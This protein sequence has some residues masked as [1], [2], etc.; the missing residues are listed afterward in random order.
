[1]RFQPLIGEAG[2]PDALNLLKDLAFRMETYRNL[3]SDAF[4]I[5]QD[6]EVRH[7]L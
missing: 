6:L 1:M 2:E 5:F 4:T 7:Q 3:G